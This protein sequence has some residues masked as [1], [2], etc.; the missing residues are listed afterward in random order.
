MRSEGS[1]LFYKTI[2]GVRLCW[3]LEE[4]KVPQEHDLW[5]RR[6]LGGG[7]RMAAVCPLDPLSYWSSQ[8]RRTP[9]IVL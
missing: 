2:S 7:V 4:P 3:E 6:S 1:M 8:H 9:K 5:L